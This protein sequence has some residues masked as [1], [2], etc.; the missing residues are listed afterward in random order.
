MTINS[1]QVAVSTVATSL[2]SGGD[3]GVRLTLSNPSGPTVYLGNSAVSGTT[4]FQYLGTAAPLQ[5]YVEQQ[6]TLYGITSSGT[7][8]VH[9][10]RGGV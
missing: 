7:A 5:V 6:E 10:L 4:G 9:V 8:T 3:N 2:A 1:A